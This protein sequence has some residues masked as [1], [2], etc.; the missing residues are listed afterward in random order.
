MLVHV[1]CVTVLDRSHTLV[2][3][4]KWHD[5]CG[6]L[7]ASEDQPKKRWLMAAVRRP[8]KSRSPRLY[9]VFG[10]FNVLTGS[11]IGGS[12]P[13]SVPAADVLHRR[14]ERQPVSLATD[15]Q[16]GEHAEI[17]E[18]ENTFGNDARTS[19]RGA[20]NTNRSSWGCEGYEPAFQEQST[21]F[22]LPQN[23]I[24]Y[25]VD[26]G[27]TPHRTAGNGKAGNGKAGKGTS[28]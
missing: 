4:R 15:S 8:F 20:R 14:G 24:S 10:L 18:R 23:T 28:V 1:S 6:H 19:A 11:R 17:R 3:A 27:E 16:D 22:G 25:P 21:G 2:L 13:S 5:P 7:L 12:N 26:S 9:I